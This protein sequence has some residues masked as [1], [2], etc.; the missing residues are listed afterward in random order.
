MARTSQNSVQQITSNTLVHRHRLEEKAVYLASLMDACPV[1]TPKLQ[2]Q[3]YMII[4]YALV[5][6]FSQK[7]KCFGDYTP[8][9]IILPMR[10]AG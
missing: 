6:G 7:F 10:V 9:F 4:W 2:H 5:Q 8:T 3:W 1:P